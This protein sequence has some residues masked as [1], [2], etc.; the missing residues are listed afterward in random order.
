MWAWTHPRVTWAWTW[1]IAK[2]SG[3]RVNGTAWRKKDFGEA[4]VWVYDSSNF[5]IFYWTLNT[6]CSL[7]LRESTDSL[8]RRLCSWRYPHQAAHDRMNYQYIIGCIHTRPLHVH[9]WIQNKPSFSY[10]TLEKLW[11]HGKYWVVP[12]LLWDTDSPSCR[13]WAVVVGMPDL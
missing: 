12:S 11:K 1:N 7:Y 6:S 2:L 4:L 3:Y 8:F 13:P 9:M 10:S 5:G